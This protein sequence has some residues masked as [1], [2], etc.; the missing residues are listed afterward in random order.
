MSLMRSFPEARKASEDI[1]ERARSY[2][3]Q[4]LESK[5]AP[6][7][8]LMLASSAIDWMLKDKGYKI[9]S[10]YSRIEQAVSDN[11]FTPEMSKWAH[12]I[13]LSG[14][15]P[16][17]ADEDHLGATVQDVEQILHF[18]ESLGEYLY[19]LPAKIKKWNK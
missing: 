2:L 13:R 6:D 15:E 3:Q 14:N 11:L 5:H 9:G 16:R 8:A 12:E 10:L 7:G 1:P 18:A 19:V 17:H 4:A